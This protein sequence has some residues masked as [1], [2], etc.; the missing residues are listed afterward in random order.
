MFASAL[1]EARTLIMRGDYDPAIQ[2][3]T[4]HLDSD[5]YHDEALFL[6]G[7]CLLAKGRNGLAAVITSAAVDARKT[8]QGKGFPEA[9]MNLGVCYMNE[10]HNDV[11]ERIWLDA[12]KVEP[13][14]KGRAL[15]L[16]NI[17]GLYTHAGQPERAIEYCDMALKEDP[18]CH[19]ARAQRGMACLEL[20]RWAEGWAGW[21]STYATGDRQKR[22]YGPGISEWDGS[23]GKTVIVWGDQGIGDE[24]WGAGC[25]R[26]M[27]RVCKRV[28]FE[29]HP[30]LTKLFQR[31]FPEIEVHGTR[32]VLSEL[33]WLADSGAE[34]AI[35]MADMPGFLRNTDE[36]WGDGAPY[37][38][39]E[40]MTDVGDGVRHEAGGP[41]RIGLSWTGGTKRTKTHLRSIPIN[42]LEPILKARPDAQWFSLQY[43][44]N[45][46]REVCEFEE[47]TG[48][49]ISHFPGWVECFDYDK[50]ASFVD[51]LDLVIT[52]GTAVHDLA[53]ALGV[54]NWVLIPSR[55][56]WRFQIKGNLPWYGSARPFRQLR[57]GDW[58]GIVKVLAAELADLK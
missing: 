49:R 50:T 46:A 28:I 21:R 30:R 37:L 12:L 31:S 29:C 53:S 44:D 3:L 39:A 13:L 33:P 32:K 4:E 54:P 41:M 14:A 7:G 35:A 55:P 6:L 10:R 38:K 36:S 9:M 45:A 15:I 16:V 24:L 42:E 2:R 17:A 20:G 43:T 23:P 51:S 34:A 19:G 5:F 25:L 40:R 47:R 57:D 56:G 48:I 8:K 52:V 11:A 22:N 26:D 58:T 1:D 18:K 27:Q